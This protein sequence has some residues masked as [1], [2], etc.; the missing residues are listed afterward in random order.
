MNPDSTDPP[1]KP[2]QV[3]PPDPDML[4]IPGGTFQMGSEDFYPEEHPIHEVIVDGFWMDRHPVTNAEFA[5]FVEATGYTTVAERPL[6]PADFPGAPAEN[7][8]PGALVF[9][10]ARGPGR[11]PGL[12]ELVGLGPRCQLESSRRTGELTHGHRAASRRPRRLRG[13]RS[14][15]AVGGQGATDRGR[16]GVRRAWRPRQQE[17]RLGGRA[18]P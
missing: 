17:V 8:V 15:C 3:T 10:K 18:L 9:Q 1:Q 13:C 5:R 6:N 16:V 11:S 4:W 7:L 2:T 14:L 12:R